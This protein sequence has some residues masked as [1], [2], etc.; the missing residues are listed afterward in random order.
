MTPAVKR[1]HTFT[2]V[3][4]GPAVAACR[5]SWAPALSLA[6]NHPTGGMLMPVCQNASRPSRGARVRQ[7]GMAV[8]RGVADTGVMPDLDRSPGPDPAGLDP[9]PVFAAWPGK[10]GRFRVRNRPL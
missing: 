10:K 5:Q 9:G 1:L 2:V 6:R 3:S 7:P 4:P 8:E